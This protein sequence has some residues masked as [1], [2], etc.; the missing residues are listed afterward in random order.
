MVTSFGFD[1]FECTGV[2]GNVFSSTGL[3]GIPLDCVGPRGWELGRTEGGF[4]AAPG[5]V[6]EKVQEA[7]GLLERKLLGQLSRN[8]PGTLPRT[9]GQHT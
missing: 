3:S 9:C 6:V 5:L 1:S 2:G 7:S 4:L 8:A